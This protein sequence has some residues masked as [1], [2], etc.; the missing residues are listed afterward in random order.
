M[1]KAGL[2]SSGAHGLQQILTPQDVLTAKI[3]LAPVLVLSGLFPNVVN[4][5]IRKRP[6]GLPEW[7]RGEMDRSSP[8]FPRHSS[9][10]R[11]RQESTMLIDECPE[12]PACPQALQDP[13]RS[14][15]SSSIGSKITRVHGRII[16][17]R[18]GIPHKQGRSRLGSAASRS[19]SHYTLVGRRAR[20]CPPLKELRFRNRETGCPWI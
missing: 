16:T 5:A 12:S 6:S 9:L 8:R 4:P 11:G 19:Y 13:I 14:S 7:L 18:E 10:P 15:D 3:E 2:T 1:S 20:F 17:P